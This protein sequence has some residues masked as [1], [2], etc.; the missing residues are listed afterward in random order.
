MRA[1]QHASPTT[2]AAFYLHE[3][4]LTGIHL[5]NGFHPAGFHGIAALARLAKIQIDMQ[6]N[7]FYHGHSLNKEKRYAMVLMQ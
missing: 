7:G 3:R 4:N 1:G 2:A 6:G 5:D